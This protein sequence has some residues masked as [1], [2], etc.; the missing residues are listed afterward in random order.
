M[1]YRR[2]WRTHQVGTG[3][4]DTCQDVECPKDHFITNFTGSYPVDDKW[5]GV[6]DID[7]KV[8]K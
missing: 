8:G 6:L 1:T 3:K 7:G 5:D 2:G 4:F